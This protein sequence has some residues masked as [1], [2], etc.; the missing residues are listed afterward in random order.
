MHGAVQTPV[1]EVE[2]SGPTASANAA[3]IV[4]CVNAHDALVAALAALIDD[5]WSDIS[6][7]PCVPTKATLKVA[8]AALAKAGL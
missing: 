3:H 8:R 5:S 6:N 2:G 7:Q 1:A 4:K